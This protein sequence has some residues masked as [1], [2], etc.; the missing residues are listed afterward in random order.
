[1]KTLFALVA[2]VL[3]LAASAQAQVLLS[4]DWETGMDGWVYYGAGP[5]PELDPNANTTPGGIYS[6]KTQDTSA[7]TSS[8]A[9][10][11][12]FAAETATSWSISWTFYDKGSTRE[13]LQVQSYDSG[14]ALQNLFALGA[15]YSVTNG[16]TYYASRVAVGSTNW[17][18][19]TAARGLDQWHSMKIAQD[20]SGLVTFWVDGVVADQRT[21][22]AVYGATRIRV[23]SGLSNVYGANYDDIV[24]SQVVP[25]PSSLMALA[26]G[27]AGLAGLARSRRR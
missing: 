23:G 10:D 11:W 1:M 17:M 9:V 5:Y 13:Y 22:T 25:E 7:T 21:T 14:G 2:A 18:T 16:T 19:T 8:N 27:L 6:L 26:A 12:N 24:F 3:L 20:S 15:Y 4:E